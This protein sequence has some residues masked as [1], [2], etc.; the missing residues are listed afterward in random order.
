MQRQP[1]KW[2]AM[3][4]IGVG[5]GWGLA[6]LS[7]ARRAEAATPIAAGNAETAVFSAEKSANGQLVFV[8]DPRAQV[9]SVY[10]FDTKKSR[11]KLAA[12][13]HYAADHQL[14]EYNNEAPNVADIEK[15]VRQQ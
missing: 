7:S 6:E 11:L 4:A 10:E 9:L 1:G 2:I 3:L 8:V 15:L 13:R 14:S 5:L 12:V